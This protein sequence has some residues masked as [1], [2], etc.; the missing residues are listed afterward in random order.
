MKEGTVSENLDYKSLWE[1]AMTQIKAEIGAQNF[2]WWLKLEYTGASEDGILV[3]TPSS[4]HRDNIINRYSSLIDETMQKLAGKKI[5]INIKASDT[6]PEKPAS[7]Q[8]SENQPKTE[9]K[10]KNL[11]KINERPAKKQIFPQLNKDFVFDNYVIGDT[12]QFAVNAALAVSKNPGTAYNPLF[13]YSGVGL[14]K[15]HLMQAIG[16]YVYQNTD[17]RIIYTTAESF[18]ND[19]TESIKENSMPGFRAKYRQVNLLLIDDIHFLE[20]KTGLQE[21]LFN[22]FN[23]LINA[24]NHMVFTCDRPI[25]ELKHF[26]ERLTSRLGSGLSVDL[27]IPQYEMRCAILQKKIEERNISIQNDVIDLICKNIS[28]N[29]RDLV[30]A[31]NKLIGY[32]ELIRKPIT[33]SVAQ[34]QLQDMFASPKQSNVSI[35]NIQQIVANYFSLS[36]NDLKGKKRTKNIV[37]PRQLAMYI[38]KSITQFSLT[39]IGQSFGGRDHTTVLHSL[40]IIEDRLKSDPAEDRLI[41]NLTKSVKEFSVK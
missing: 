41:Q 10:S 11:I 29:V 27:Q 18:L 30:A 38:I 14:G 25:S 5:K 2:D 34:D 9:E 16:N 31:L 26:S 20:N 12:N 35:E 28:S 37:Y 3:S 6:I 8:T 33:L 23:A 24:K 36:V 40:K 19:Y 21:E 17:N 15:T 4:F 32:A 39:D 13:I 7:A 1:T 22:T